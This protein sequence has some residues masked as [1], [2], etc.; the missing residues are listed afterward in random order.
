M[1][2]C[3]DDDL[4]VTATL[5]TTAARAGAH[6]FVSD[7]EAPSPARAG[8][9]YDNWRGLGFEPVYRRELFAKG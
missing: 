5:L 8:R 9:A 4:R 6:S 1:A 2:P 3:F 7:I